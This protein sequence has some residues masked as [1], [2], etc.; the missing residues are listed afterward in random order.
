MTAVAARPGAHAPAQP[1]AGE[2]PLWRQ[3][4]VPREHGGWGL[5]LEPVLLGLLIAPSLPGAALGLAAFAAFLVRTPLKLAVGDVRR[6]QWQQ[7]SRLAGRFAAAELVLITLCAAVGV[8]AAADLRWLLP[9]A[10]AAPFVA[11]EL[12]F[13]VRGHGRRLV[14]ELCGSVGIAAAT[15]AIVLAGGGAWRLAVGAWLVLTARSLGAIPFVRAQIMRVRRS[16]V[17]GGGVR[18][19][20]AAQAAALVVGVIAVMLDR[21]LTV[22]LGWL[23]LLAVLQIVWVRRA[24]SPPKVLGIRQMALGVGLVLATSAGVWML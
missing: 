4:A 9:V 24:P 23:V 8:L 18:H 16:E 14:P 20:D 17:T 2:R 21:R 3:V 12:W 5:T 10:A 6:H 1:P 13:D 15:A 11:V 19:S 22:G 7:R